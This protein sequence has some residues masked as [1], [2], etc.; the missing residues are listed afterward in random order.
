MFSLIRSLTIRHLLQKW[1][2]SLLVAISIALGVTMFVSSRLLNQCTEAAAK[3]TTIPVDIADLYVTS[4]EQGVDWIVA[5]QIRT[6]QI[7]GVNRVSRFVHLRVG[8]PKLKGRTAVV[9][10]IDVSQSVNAI[11]QDPDQLKR[12]LEEWRQLSEKWKI[13]IMPLGGAGLV[14][15]YPRVIISR[16]TYEQLR[17]SGWVDA[18]PLELKYT[19][20]PKK[21]S[22][23]GVI[24]VAKDSPY[25]PFADNM[26]AMEASTAAKLMDR[27][28]EGGG[29]RVSRID[30]F[31]DKGVDIQSVREQVAQVVGD[32]ASVRTAEANRKSTEEIIGGVKLVLNLSAVASMVVGLFLVYIVLWVNVAERRHDIGVMRSLGAT[33]GQ[34]ARLFAVEAIILGGIGSLPGIPLGVALSDVAV[35][36]FASADLTSA[37]LNGESSFRTVLTPLT[38]ILAVSAGMITALLAALIPSLQAA[39]DE[40]AD[41]VR[42]A[43]TRTRGVIRIVHR[44]AC[45]GLIASGLILFVGRNYL[46]SRT[47][48]MTAALLIFIGLLLALPI[49]VSVIARLLNPAIRWL[50]GVEAR[51]AIDNL[52]RARDAPAW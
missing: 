7:P 19:N 46:P 36:I 10:G 28:A 11:A 45:V 40:P 25:A 13:A 3:D 48:S 52:V 1:D 35:R 47:G 4:G 38:A 49:V 14:S 18:D 5:D 43:P 15:E 6:A 26:I 21:F 20:E 17:Q 30:L 44:L 24:D 31:L 2:R 34:I 32:R 9:F 22:V 39:S 8:L 29:Y 37:F 27:P 42:R 50:L 41:A 12:L 16:R 33:R 23:F 51:L